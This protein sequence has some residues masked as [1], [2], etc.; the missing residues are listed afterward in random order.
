[1][2]G[3]LQSAFCKVAQSGLRCC[4]NSAWVRLFLRQ[5]AEPGSNA[6]SPTRE[7]IKARLAIRSR[8]SRNPSILPLQ[9]GEAVRIRSLDTA[10]K[11]RGRVVYMHN[12]CA[13]RWI[14]RKA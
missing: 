4:A 6:D 12:M 8:A 7:R 11:G 5:H 1:M 2:L 14:S 9:S 3:E 13:D 10:R